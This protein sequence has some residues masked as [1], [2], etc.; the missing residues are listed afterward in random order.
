MATTRDS[1]R[2][3]NYMRATSLSLNIS[4][5]HLTPHDRYQERQCLFLTLWEPREGAFHVR[6]DIGKLEGSSLRVFGLGQSEH[7]ALGISSWH[8]EPARLLVSPTGCGNGDKHWGWVD[9]ATTKGSRGPIPVE[10][11][12][13]TARSTQHVKRP[14]QIE[15]RDIEEPIRARHPDNEN[16][17]WPVQI[18]PPPERTCDETESQ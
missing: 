8:D 2:A 5:V 6:L 18:P 3:G 7:L 1:T 15:R 12:S 11:P 4:R 13:D 10:G 17:G 14:D 16:L 9:G